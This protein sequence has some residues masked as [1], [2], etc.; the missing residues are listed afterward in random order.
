MFFDNRMLRGVWQK[1][2]WENL[3]LRIWGT[4][5]SI[6]KSELFSGSLYFIVFTS[7]CFFFAYQSN[8][9]KLNANCK[10]DPTIGCLQQ[11]L[12][13]MKMGDRDFLPSWKLVLV[14]VHVCQIVV[15]IWNRCP[16]QSDLRTIFL[17]YNLARAH[18]HTSTQLNE[19]PSW[20]C[21]ISYCICLYVIDWLQICSGWKLIFKIIRRT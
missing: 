15:V 18:T 14:Y 5:F 8:Q 17:N 21:I 20:C 6:P 16:S 12:V 1:L 10:V 3:G 7:W 13:A 9:P 4:K 2:L 11:L 19:A